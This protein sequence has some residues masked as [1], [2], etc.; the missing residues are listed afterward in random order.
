MTSPSEMTHSPDNS[1]ARRLSPAD[2]NAASSHATGSDHS[3]RAQGSVVYT[4]LLWPWKLTWRILHILFTYSGYTD[5][6]NSSP[7]LQAGR[8]IA[9]FERQNGPQR[10]PFFEGAYEQAVRR[11]KEDLKGLVVVLISEEHDDTPEFCRRIADEAFSTFLEHHQL[12]I[13]GGNVRYADAYQVSCTL[14]VSQ[15][16]FIGVV[17]PRTRN[18]GSMRMAVIERIEGLRPIDQV[19]AQIL[20][21]VQEANS[22][23]LSMRRARQERE[24]AAL[25]R[26]QQD[27]AYE[28]SLRADQEKERR[29]REQREAEERH[30]QE[31]IRQQ[32]EHQRMLALKAQYQQYLLA[33]SAPEPPAGEPGVARFGIRFPDGQRVTRRFYGADPVEKIYQFVETYPLMLDASQATD[34]QGSPESTNLP[35]RPSD[36]E[37]QC[38]FRLV[39][40]MP[41]Q[42]FDNQ[43]LT[44]REA[45]K[46][47]WPS[48]TLIVEPLDEEV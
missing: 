1:G 9:E 25:L 35:Q 15:F 19:M 31:I 48:T 7:R 24:A 40:P 41:R 29:L 37:H 26:Q 32:Q 38:D 18:G 27:E 21:K 45:F 5:P 42:V 34:T 36:Y 13:W 23:L 4:M 10:P 17:M 44:I 30:Q 33:T 28:R 20:V 2:D 16:P 3:I 8:F 43:S 12:T 22:A 6:T 47:H 46:G 11:A 14:Q 39:A